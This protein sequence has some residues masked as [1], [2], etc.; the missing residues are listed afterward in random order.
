MRTSKMLV[1]YKGGPDPSN[2]ME[3]RTIEEYF[4]Y[5][6][7]STKDPHEA[8]IHLSETECRGN[9]DLDK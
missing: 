7:Y 4:C 1:R 8:F 3:G 6:G 9:K 5:C 2:P